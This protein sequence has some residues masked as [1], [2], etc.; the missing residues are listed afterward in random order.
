MIKNIT[1]I[2]L[3]TFVGITS[4][5]VNAQV[6]KGNVI[7][8]A[9]YGFPNLYTSAFKTLY[10][11]SGSELNLKVAGLGPLGIRG[12]YLVADKFGIGLDIHY[13]QS[14][15]DY[16]QATNDASGNAVVY[17]YNYKTTKIAIMPSFNFHFLEEDAM[18]LYLQVAAGY[19]NRT[20]AFTSTDPAYSNPS[21]KGLIPV[22][23]RLAVGY[24]Y[25]FTENLGINMAVGLGGPLVSGGLSLK[26]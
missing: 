24:R 8:D 21:V 3:L 5:A 2:A 15:I 11:N 18:D 10:A 25:F 6:E 20:Y 12:E 26:F 23:F 4:T 22:A 1:K 13:Q 7:V 14:S 9:Y 19:G 17:N 16:N